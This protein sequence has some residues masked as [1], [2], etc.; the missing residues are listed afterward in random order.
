M[1]MRAAGR[2]MRSQV[3]TAK[4]RIKILKVE[5]ANAQMALEK[6][7]NGSFMTEVNL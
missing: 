4:D 1:E 2:T 7:A 6:L 5:F 3:T